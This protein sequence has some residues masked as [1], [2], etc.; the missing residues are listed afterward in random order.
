MPPPLKYT[1][2]LAFD[3]L[4]LRHSFFPPKPLD[5]KMP[6]QSIG[7]YRKSTFDSFS[8]RI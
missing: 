5:V 8:E 2:A 6:L 1:P 7:H 3:G 4:Q